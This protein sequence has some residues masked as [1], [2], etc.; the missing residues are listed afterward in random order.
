M[1]EFNWQQDAEDRREEVITYTPEPEPQRPKRRWWL[2][3]VVLLAVAVA[4]WLIYQQAERRVEEATT[5]VTDDVLSSH[6]LLLQAAYDNDP[7]LFVA[8]L[9]GRDADWTDVQKAMLPA[10]VFLDRP[11][12]GLFAK[13]EQAPTLSNIESQF[14]S[15]DFSPDLLSAELVTSQAYT[16]TLPN[17]TLQSTTLQQMAVYRRGSQRWRNAP[18]EPDFW[19]ITADY[20]RDA[21]TA[22]Y[23]WRDETFVQRLA[24]D[25]EQ[26]LG[27]LCRTLDGI[28]CPAE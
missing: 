10:D 18:P 23:P 17:G 12:L 22:V 15:L 14:V 20:E 9:S 19:G 13:R 25:L 2:V 6:R 27:Q 7:D 8:L 16:F 3:S 26:I 24:M 21:V 28:D 11:S 5:A 1:S 4:G